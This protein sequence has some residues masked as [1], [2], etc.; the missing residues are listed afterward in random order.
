MNQPRLYQ[1][2]VAVAVAAGIFVA[3]TGGLLAFNAWRGKVTTLVNSKEV[4]NLHDELRKQPKNEAMKQRIRQLDLQLRQETFYRLELSHNASRALLWGAAIFLAS[5]HFAR[6]AQRRLPNPLAWGARQADEERRIQRFARYAVAGVFALAGFSA[7]VLSQQPV[8]LPVRMLSEV[9]VTETPVSME[10]FARQWPAFRGPHGQGVAADAAISSPVKI[11]WKTSVPLP[12]MSSPIVWNNAVFLT[13]AT[14]TENR[15]FQFNAETG[16]LVW[17]AVVNAPKPSKPDVMSDTTFAAPTAVSDGRRVY[18]MFAD[19]LVAAFDFNGKQVWARNVGPVDNSYG[20]ASSLALWQDRLLLQID[21][22][23]KTSRLVALDTRTGREL[24]SK[25]REVAGAWA[26]PVIVESKLVTCAAPLVI[27]Y[28]P[29]DGRE[30][31]RN[32]CLDGDVAASPV[33]AGGILVA[34]APNNAI[35]GL[36]P[37]ETGTVWKATDGVPEATSPVIDGNRVYAVADSG[38]MNCFDLQTGKVIWMHEFADT[39][40]A[41]PTLAGKTLLLL[42]RKGVLT[43]LAIGDEYRE[44]GQTELGEE[45]NASPAP[46]GHRLYVRGKQHLFCLETELQ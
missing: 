32:Q 23:E 16:A 28:N 46:V 35:I 10:E 8:R 11:R 31:W 7:V 33:F 14:E 39:F 2:A 40:Y 18:A 41:S 12:G 42:S 21:R 34:V 19:G 20:Y 38:A 5:A 45:C 17:S 43:L 4:V 15:V 36:R 6:T 24:W 3:L 1:L 29:L 9:V 27:A 25:P 30:L 44:L 13:G 22:E 37:G 26:S